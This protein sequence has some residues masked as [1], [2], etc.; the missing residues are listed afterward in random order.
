MLTFSP[1]PP[2]GIDAMLWR[3]RRSAGTALSARSLGRL[4]RRLEKQRVELD[5]L[6]E[7]LEAEAASFPG[8]RDLSDLFDASEA[9]GDVVDHELAR[10][11]AA[12]ARSVL[13]EVRRALDR[14]D[15]GSYGRCE[16]CEDA[17]PL[18]RLEA[19]PTTSRCAVC[20]RREE[21]L[22]IRGRPHQPAAG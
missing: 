1:P 8:G 17:I 9:Y 10:A 16:G 4:Q 3:R 14:I 19:L 6:V 18:A 22:G 2:S 21:D 7:E 13:A 11:R 12:G 20:K 15:A 5:H